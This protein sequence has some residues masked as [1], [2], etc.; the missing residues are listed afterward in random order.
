MG[1]SF[2]MYMKILVM[3][4]E[5][6]ENCKAIL[7][8]KHWFCPFYNIEIQETNDEKRKLFKMG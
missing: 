8:G 6:N 3:Q 4:R 5:A 1:N 7:G 2:L